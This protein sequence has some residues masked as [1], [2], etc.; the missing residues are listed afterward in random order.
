MDV[1]LNTST[2]LR[3]KGDH[4]HHHHD[5]K[6]AKVRCDDSP[7]WPW[8]CAFFHSVVIHCQSAWSKSYTGTSRSSPPD[9]V[10]LV[11]GLDSNNLLQDLMR[12]S[13]GVQ[14]GHLSE[15]HTS[16]NNCLSEKVIA[17]YY[18]QLLFTKN[19]ASQ[20]YEKKTHTTLV[21]I[22]WTIDLF[23]ALRLWAC[24]VSQP[25]FQSLICRRRCSSVIQSCIRDAT[26]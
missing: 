1:L 17:A 12:W 3:R 16:F 13:G 26:S 6:T 5:A 15:Q 20:K 8:S 23:V 14:S 24:A 22:L 10:G 9:S 11:S 21:H 7:W 19:V 2:K 18:I 25:S 4:H